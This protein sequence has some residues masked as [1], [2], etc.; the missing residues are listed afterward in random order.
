[1]QNYAFLF[2]LY[3]LFL[4]LLYLYYIYFIILYYYKLY[5]AHTAIAPSQFSLSV[6]RAAEVKL[7]EQVRGSGVGFELILHG[8]AHYIPNLDLHRPEQLLG[9]KRA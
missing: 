4:Y 3:E 2:W 7:G 1:M 8:A 6:F 5:C 9:G